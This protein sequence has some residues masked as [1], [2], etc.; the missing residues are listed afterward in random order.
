M[1]NIRRGHHELGAEARP[2]LRVAAAID[3]LLDTI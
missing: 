2:A 3:E 1:Q